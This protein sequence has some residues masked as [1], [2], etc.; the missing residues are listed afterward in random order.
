VV[1]VPPDVVGEELLPPVGLPC[2]YDVERLVVEHR[3][4]TRT[5][6]AV[7]AAKRGH[8]DAAGAAVEGMEPGVTGLG[9]QFVRPNLADHPRRPQVGFGVEDVGPRRSQPG[10]DQVAAFEV[11]RVPGV[12]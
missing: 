3:D 11:T 6:V 8:E 1:E 4:A 2:A 5:V 9:G 7:G 10:H 12:T